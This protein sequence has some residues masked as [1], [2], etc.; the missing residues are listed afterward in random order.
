MNNKELPIKSKTPEKILAIAKAKSKKSYD[1]TNSKF[2]EFW[3]DLDETVR[4]DFKEFIKSPNEI[5]Y[6]LY[7][8]NDNNWTLLTIHNLIGKKDGKIKKAGLQK[9]K[10]KDFGI[11]KR[12][13]NVPLPLIVKSRFMNYE[14]E[15]E[16][17]GPQGLCL[18]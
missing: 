2:T 4:I 12:I 15:Y 9:I 17:N 7:F 3:N 14:F 13:Y 8:R 18:W 1:L 5:G 10:S 6:L 16:S 11:I